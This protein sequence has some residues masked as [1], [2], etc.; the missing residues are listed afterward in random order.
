MESLLNWVST[1]GPIAIFILLILGIVGL[2]IP[3]ETLLVFSGYLIS[4]GKMNAPATYFAAIIGSWFGTTISYGIGRTLGLTLIHRFGKYLHVD[5]KKLQEIHAW[6]DRR[7]HWA[8]FVGY[9]IAG[10]RHFTAIVAGASGV[11]LRTFVLYGWSGGLLWATGFLTLGYYLGEQWRQI[12]D[13]IHHYMLLASIVLL[14]VAGL[15]GLWR[16]KQSRPVQVIV[17]KQRH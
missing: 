8:L 7:G 15:Y 2:P 10:I 5:D 6:V 12:F 9:Y 16:W 1:N 17:E 13:L 3:D 14:A 4:K 11:E